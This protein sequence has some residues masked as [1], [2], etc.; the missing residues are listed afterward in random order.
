MRVFTHALLSHFLVDEHRECT[1][2][3]TQWSVFFSETK[4]LT[5]TTEIARLF[6]YDD[7]REVLEYWIAIKL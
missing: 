6:L 3:A 2:D 7:N 1:F 4:L 5:A